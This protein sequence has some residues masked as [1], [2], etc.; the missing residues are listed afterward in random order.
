MQFRVGRL[1][2]QAK[3]TLNFGRP[4][5]E[6]TAQWV[7]A[8][9]DQRFRRTEDLIVAAAGNL[10]HGVLD[11][12]EALDRLRDGATLFSS[13]Q[14]CALSDSEICSGHMGC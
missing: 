8:L 4:M 1:F 12:A 11:L 3:R 6:V 7:R 13:R 10:S 14:S 2:V 5:R 9:Q